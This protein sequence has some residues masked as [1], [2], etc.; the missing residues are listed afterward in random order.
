MQA[1]WYVDAGGLRRGPLS[2]AQLAEMA[3]SGFLKPYDQVCRSGMNWTSA[4]MVPGLFS[5]AVEFPPAQPPVAPHLTPMPQMTPPAPRMPY[6]PPMMQPAPMTAPPVAAA[7]HERR[8]TDDVSYAGSRMVQKQSAAGGRS[9]A[10]VASTIASIIVGAAAAVYVYMNYE[11]LINRL[12][13]RDRLL[14]VEPEPLLDEQ[15]APVVSPAT[16]KTALPTDARRS[17]R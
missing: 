17:N 8:P 5:G 7:M 1:D 14:E 9:M 10:A 15:L 4:A 12:T 3:Q 11:P 16:S 6:A 2:D 13:G